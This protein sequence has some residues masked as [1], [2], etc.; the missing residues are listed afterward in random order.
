M[1]I[2]SITAVHHLVFMGLLSQEFHLL[3]AGDV[4]GDRF[5]QHTGYRKVRPI[6]ISHIVH[7]EREAD[8]IAVDRV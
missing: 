2:L 6:L 7:P 4:E 1:P 8:H 3:N 5:V